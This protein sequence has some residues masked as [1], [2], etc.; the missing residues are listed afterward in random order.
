MASYRNVIFYNTASFCITP[1]CT[2]SR[3]PFNHRNKDIISWD[4]NFHSHKLS[5]N[6][7]N[8]HQELTSL[9]ESEVRLHRVKRYSGINDLR[10]FNIS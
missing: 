3:R 7:V 4:I 1:R 2:L 9:S 8:K 6:A 5:L 10:A